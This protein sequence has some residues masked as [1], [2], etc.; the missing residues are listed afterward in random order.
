[1]SQCT[2]GQAAVAEVVDGAVALALEWRRRAASEETPRE[3]ATN[4]QLAG[5]L[6]D[7][8]GLA[9]AVRF[10]DEVARA[11]DVHVAAKVLAT[12]RGGASFL[13]PA[14]RLLL[15][16]GAMV[17]PLAPQ[18]VVP[19]ARRRLRQMVGHLLVD[20]NDPALAR[21]L[22]RSRA[23]GVTLNVNLL[24]EAVLGEAE[25]ASRV[26]RT[27]DLLQRADVDYVSV[28]VSS[29][30]SQISP[31][32]TAGTVTRIA[33]PLRDIYR[34]AA[35]RS[36]HGFVNLDMEEYAD[37]DLTLA[38][39][40]T[41]L[42]EPEFL[43]LEA[44][45]ALQAYLP[46][47]LGALEQ[48][49]DFATRRRDR[50]GAGIKVRVVKG[51]N[52]AMESVQA[53]VHGW[54]TAPY[55]TKADVD[56]NYLRVVE[57]ALRPDATDVIRLGVASHNLFDVAAA[58]LLAQRRG[59]GHRLD[60][61]MLQG[62]SPAQARVVRSDVHTMV[63]Y[64]PV[65]A[66][67][68]FDVAVSYLVRRLEENA[69][70][71]NFL[72][73]MASDEGGSSPAMAR[74]ERWFRDSV[75][76]MDATP[77]RR[78]RTPGRPAVDDRFANTPDSD[79]ALSE[80]RRWALAAVAARP[81]EPRTPLASTA[82]I[83]A[84]V[85]TA[86]DA[87]PGW[88]GRTPCARAA[89]LREGARQMEARRGDL[90]TAMA[91]EGGKTIAQSDPEVSEAIDFARFYAD[92][93][94]DLGPG[95]A[96]TDGAR[97]EPAAVTLVTPPWNFPVAIPL[98]GVLAALASGSCVIIK[99]AQAVPRCTEIGVEA[100]WAAG[101]PREV[102]HVV[103]TDEH[104]VGQ[105]LV[106][107]P[108]VDA[109]VLTG[110][111]E[112]AELFASWRTGRSSGPRVHAETSGKNA[113]VITPAADID[114]AVVDLVASAFGHAGQ[115]CS[116][117]SL[118]ILVGSVGRSRR[119]RRQLV[120]AVRS[121]RVGWP[122]DPGATMGPVIEPPEGKLLRALTT[123]D[124]EERWLVEPHQLDGSG[125]LWS[126][127]LKEGVAPG[128]FFHH[129][130]VFGPVLGLM[131]ASTL[132]EAITWQN[133]TRFGL[134]GGLHSL[135]P[136]D[137]RTW[138]SRVEVGNAY[139][140]RGTTGAMVRRQ[141]FG[142]WKDSS[143]GPGAKAGGPNYVASLGGWAPDGLPRL[144]RRPL[145]R[146][147]ALSRSLAPLVRTPSEKEWFDA[148]LESDAH[149]W[150][151]E[152]GHAR[153][154]SGLVS[155]QNEFRYCPVPQLVLHC[156]DGTRFVELARV[157][158]AASLAGTPVLLSL[159]SAVA[160]E[161]DA[162]LGSSGPG[163]ALADA[164]A[165]QRV[166]PD[167][168]MEDWVQHSTPGTRVRGLGD[169]TGLYDALSGSGVDVSAGPVLATGRRELLTVLREQSVSRTLH[170]FGHVPP[171]LRR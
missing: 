50:G 166:V 98:G 40:E 7:D 42:L 47:A 171:E 8:A 95:H 55:D 133:A 108:G 115:K 75:A 131:H 68:D 16:A 150:E 86:R 3:R 94:E 93:A 45:I 60:V 59:A 156:E 77:S 33:E 164:L 13:G 64:T 145:P 20:A 76:A 121:L 139:I 82:D 54:A 157:L 23:D 35:A 167:G 141:P 165:V 18:L 24:G 107:H 168:R 169:A 65:V 113:L 124:G 74:Q 111:V 117:A 132:D 102:L 118:G 89:I 138:T 88:A 27:I 137:I 63:L 69:Q 129:T 38:V 119:F 143:V 43:H 103:R 58:H 152:F 66:P 122:E 15:W 84:V 67:K 123:L 4:G 160:A 100:L 90:V 96:M 142:G 126:P 148:A 29:L 151:T 6:S 163:R 22:A 80:T 161:L 136:D 71:Q 109:V 85:A 87:A 81:G 48:L 2:H 153:D 12:L 158:A 140:N 104:G 97:F 25:A 46:D 70:P 32:D 127:G 14:D 146:I 91:A 170:R 125:R 61:E 144:R 52:L 49:I 154:D 128:S 79:P 92:A 44:G 162:L 120:D 28:K 62:M 135:D 78:R 106:A 39:F 56:A 31:W 99:P 53:E 147:T 110:A 130:E 112:T 83:D 37:L 134:T 36:P 41:L 19:L 73:A 26:R 57:R 159:G 17:A 9:L 11:E 5:M 34:A 21:H 116:A 155:E 101:V 51:A 114:L 72:H 10:V 149:A 30:V 1:M 105:H